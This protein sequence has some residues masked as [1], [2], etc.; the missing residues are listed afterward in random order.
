MAFSEKEIRE[1]LQRIADF[2][3]SV[4]VAA[5]VL[6]KGA[7]VPETSLLVSLPTA[8][9]FPEEES[10]AEIEDLHLAS[11]NLVDLSDSEEKIS[12]YLS[13]Y[14]PVYADHGEKSECEILRLVNEMNQSVRIGHFFYAEMEDGEGSMV[15]YRAELMGPA[16]EPLDEA[17][18]AEVVLEM[19][20]GY[21]RM[22]EALEA[23]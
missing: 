4:D 18:V 21:D 20:I 14:A 16:D 13:I 15:Q 9:A 11:M 17:V 2:L 3:D 1:E 23:V 8:F 10:Q 12:K 5:K 19:G 6:L 22:K 7:Q